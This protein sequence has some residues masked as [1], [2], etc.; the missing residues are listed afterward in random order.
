M[1]GHSQF[2]LLTQRRFLPY[3]IVQALGAFNDNVYRQAIIGLLFFLGVGTAERSLYAILAPAIFIAPYFLFSAIAGQVAEKLEKQRLIVI[4][5]TME[6]AIMSLAAAGFLLQNMPVLLVALFCTGVQSTLF[7]PVKYSVL[8]AILKPEE[9]TGGNGLVEMGTSISILGGMIF[10]GLIF[11][12]AGA[13]GPEVAATAIIALAVAG[14]LVARRIPRVDAG[15]PELKVNWNPLPETVAV[16]RMARRQPA[17]RN[18]ILGVSWFWFFGTILTSQLPVYAELNLG[19]AAGSATLYIFVL[20]LFSVGTGTGSLLCEKLSARTVEIGL[21]PLGAFGMSAF[22]LDLYFARSGLAP[23]TGLDVAGFL[24]QPGSWRIVLDLLGIGVFAGFFVVPLFALIQS[25]S[26]N[27]EMSRVFAALNIQNSGFIVLA[28]LTALVAQ[29]GLG[30][31]SPQLFLALAIGNVLVAAWIF[32]L[33]PEFLMRFLSWLLVRALY[34]LRIRGVEAHVPDEGAALIVCNHVSYMDAL[35]LAASIPRPVRFV[36]YYRIFNIPV[37]SWIFRTAKAIPIAGAKEDPALMR[38]AFD[39]IDATLAEGELVC[40]FPEG[41]L[42]RD[43]AIAPFKSGVEKILE[44]AAAAG[45]P[46]PV[47]PM[48]LRGMWASMWSRRDSRLGRMRVPRRVR[49]RVEVVAAPAVAASPASGP[50]TAEA[51]EAQVRELRGDDA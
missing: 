47:V 33:V 1:S 2:A 34:R 20:A 17:V 8:P 25:R 51:L 36:M 29:Q 45:R 42:T 9:L 21:V 3:F 6:I 37:M 35:I 14:N 50:V 4:T 31:S 19:G 39:E 5:T 16:L 41:A 26:A 15:A 24:R 12:L 22:L 28:A 11:Q 23:A 18:A 38:R 30:W 27:S 46:V 10:G 48:A 7:G 43:G 49:A 13:H 32:A 44:R 40:I